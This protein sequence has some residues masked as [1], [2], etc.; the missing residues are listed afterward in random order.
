MLT[1]S[2]EYLDK[3]DDSTQI[4]INCLNYLAAEAERENNI[5]IS[6]ILSGASKEIYR[7][8]SSGNYDRE[9]EADILIESMIACFSFFLE[10]RKMPSPKY[11]RLVKLIEMLEDIKLH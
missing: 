1:S 8:V 10:L 3:I 9:N 11:S 5:A 6:E 2:T 4:Y 7:W